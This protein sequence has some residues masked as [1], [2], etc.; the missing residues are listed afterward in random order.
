MKVKVKL[1]HGAFLFIDNIQIERE[2]QEVDLQGKSDAFIRTLALQIACGKVQSDKKYEALIAII[3]NDGVKYETAILTGVNTSAPK[4]KIEDIIEAPVEVLEV[5]SEE[6]TE[7][8]GVADT[9]SAED[10]PE[11]ISIPAIEL[12]ELLSGTSKNVVTALKA[13]TLTED[14]KIELLGLE[15]EGKNRA[16]VKTAIEEL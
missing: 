6:V 9:V 4:V 1:I 3:E 7:V 12:A 10:L 5:I 8:E 2:T 16:T 13:A 15:E 14:Q 11:E